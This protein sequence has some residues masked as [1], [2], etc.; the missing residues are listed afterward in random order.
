MQDQKLMATANYERCL[1]A[2]RA[3]A[4]REID[5]DEIAAIFEAVDRRLEAERARG[6]IDMLEQRTAEIAREMGD[7]LRLRAAKQAQ[8]AALN[9][10]RRDALENQLM[11]MLQGGMTFPKA[12]LALLEGSTKGVEG[13]RNSVA[14]THLAFMG[15]FAGDMMAAIQ[16][17]RPHLVNRRMLTDK[18]LSDNVMREMRELRDGG[19][20]GR[21][22]DDDAKYLA[23]M[24]ATFAELSR[25]D[26][27]RLGASI[28]KLDGWSPQVHDD[29]RLLRAGK[30]KWVREIAP[31][32]DMDRTFKDVAPGD[33]PRILGDVYDNIV[34]G[35]EKGPSARA[36]GERR[37]PANLANALGKERVLHFR[38]A[39]AA[40]AY[41]DLYGF[42]NVFTAMWTHQMHAARYAAQMQ[43]F[44]PNPEIMRDSIL[45]SLKRRVRADATLTD[46]QK[47]R[48][49]ETLQA[50]QG[51]SIDS[52]WAVATGMT[53]APVNARWARI[54]SNIRGWEM[55]SKLGGAV[56]SSIS[57]LPTAALNLKFH[58][59][60]YWGALGEQ[61]RRLI[62]EGRGA[63]EAKEIAYLFGEGMEGLVSHIHVAHVA[64]DA[65]PGR[66]ARATAAFFRWNWLTWWTEANR[67]VTARIM[68]AD[69]GAKAELAHAALPE[70][71]RHVLSLHSIGAKEWDAIRQAARREV[72]GNNYITPDAV[73]ALPDEAV[74]PLIQGNATPRKLADARLNLELA[75]RRFYADE[76]RFGVIETDAAARRMTTLGTRPGTL[77]GEAVRMVMQFKGFTIAFTQRVIGRA[78][79]GAEG[80]SHAGIGHIGALIAGT[81]IAGYAAMTAKDFLRGYGPRDPTSWRT[82]LAA[83]QQGG[84]AGIY[85]DFL[86]GEANRFG[87][88]TAESVIGPAAGDAFN[89]LD[90]MKRA[91]DG[92][93]RAADLL[94]A[95]LRNTPFINLHLARPALDALILNSWREAASP[96][97]TARQNARRRQEYGQERVW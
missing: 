71:Y 70:R 2:V 22:G 81:T 23:R 84:G 51:G 47:R 63:G 17:E 82:I 46:E 13:A 48:L 60:S 15:R 86:F 87:Q 69:M 5:D 97:F 18:R 52:A 91:R 27:N 93:V 92:D 12:M 16:R 11:P 31:L 65:I 50:G 62:T 41:N 33:V 89:A 9:A 29:Y 25:T 10:I 8:H 74:A 19:N 75:L 55:L 45:E 79:Q 38:D 85:G 53:S 94:N 58:G 32:L 36:R 42:G 72:N 39:D 88:S 78:V 37:G 56:I 59:R 66:M 30:E 1:E 44:G 64:E 67:A 95:G 4:G 35:I 49:G 24:F 28:G 26:L 90:I 96:G 76:A 14:A 6:N 34:T 3:A 40:I 68:G 83:L 80:G 57:D 7:D 21:T 77:G 20:P 43:V 61:T 73:R 54:G